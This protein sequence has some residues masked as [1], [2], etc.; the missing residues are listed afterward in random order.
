MP[1]SMPDLPTSFS[2]LQRLKLKDPGPYDFLEEA[3][4]SIKA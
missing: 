4:Q 2:L 1:D 3:K